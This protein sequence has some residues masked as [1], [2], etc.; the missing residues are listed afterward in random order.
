MDKRHDSDAE[1]AL[2][3]LTER[4]REEAMSRF[5]VLQPHINEG[6]P[7]SQAAGSAGISI[8][9]ARRWLARYRQAGLVGLTRS[10]RSDTDC[11]KLAAEMIT[12]IEGMA[13]R[14]PR[15]SICNELQSSSV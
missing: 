8:R 9:T 2:A 6:I 1:T 4:Q 14:R 10:K 12:L 13:L 5:A 3:D 11:R 7:L 15:P